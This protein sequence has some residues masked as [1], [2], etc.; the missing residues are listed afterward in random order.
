M[1]P[2]FGEG[3]QSEAG[4]FEAAD[5]G[6]QVIQLFLVMTMRDGDYVVFGAGHLDDLIQLGIHGGLADIGGIQ[7]DVVSKS[8]DMR[9]LRGLKAH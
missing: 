5:K 3:N 4:L 2:I 9:F 7:E 8:S 1:A 6:F